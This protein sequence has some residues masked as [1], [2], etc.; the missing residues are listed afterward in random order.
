MAPGGQADPLICSG[1]KTSL[2]RGNSHVDNPEAIPE[3]GESVET[4]REALAN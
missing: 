3:M 1:S 4:T 2:Y